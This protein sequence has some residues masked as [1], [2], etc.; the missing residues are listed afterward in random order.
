MSRSTTALTKRKSRIEIYASKRGVHAVESP[1][2]VQILSMVREHEMP[3]EEIV[4]ASGRAKS[5]ISVHLKGMVQDGILSSKPDPRDSRRKIFFIY[6]EYLGTL[7]PADRVEEDVGAQLLASLRDGGDTSQFFKALFRAIRLSLLREGITIDP[8][9]RAAGLAVGRALYP[10]VGDPDLARTIAHLS[11]FWKRHGLG[12]LVTV[13]LSPVTIDIFDCFEC[14]D[15]PK[16]GKPA[17][18]FDAGILA[19]IFESY[20]GNQLVVT[21]THCYAMGNSHCRFEIANRGRESRT[22][23][24]AIRR[25]ADAAVRSQGRG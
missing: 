6:S 10:A 14:Q 22:T 23:R 24:Q 8:I 2:R 20:F 11:D 13:S 25:Q 19:G 12:R 3:F 17:C 4:A 9:L 5:T 18:A 16:I 21:E 7:S 1:V 15:L